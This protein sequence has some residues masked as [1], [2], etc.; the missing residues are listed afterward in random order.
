MGSPCLTVSPSLLN[1]RTTMALVLVTPPDFGTMTVVKIALFERVRLAPWCR[2]MRDSTC[3]N[4]HVS[5][6]PCRAFT[7]RR[8]AAESSHQFGMSEPDLQ[9][10]P[11]AD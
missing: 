2:P 11:S 8:C 10:S 3:L 9:K 4:D 7:C 5:A 6:L 1:Q